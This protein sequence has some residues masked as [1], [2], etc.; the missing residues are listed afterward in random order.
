MT[1][2]HKFVVGLEEIRNLVLE[3]MSKDC[4]A[5]VVFSPDK[6]DSLP[7]V[8]PHGHVWEWGEAKNIIMDSPASI[9][10]RQLRR[11]REQGNAN[12]GFKIFLEFDEPDARS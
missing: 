3:C 12:I 10:V 6:T 8:C 5:R 11:L 4:K 9:W 2:E 7:Q 1:R